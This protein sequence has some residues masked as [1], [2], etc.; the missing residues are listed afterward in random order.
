MHKMAGSKFREVSE[1][2]NAHFNKEKLLETKV[3]TQPKII[4]QYPE[5]EEEEEAVDDLQTSDAFQPHEIEN[6]ISQSEE[7]R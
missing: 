3:P 1:I 7:E 4:V 2:L 6:S 5:E